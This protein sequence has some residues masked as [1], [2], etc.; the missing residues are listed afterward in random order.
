M[1][2]FIL[3][4]IPLL[5]R[6][7]ITQEQ[8]QIKVQKLKL[9]QARQE[10]LEAD[11]AKRNKLHRQRQC[12]KNLLQ[13][14][15]DIPYSGMNC[16]RKCLILS[17]KFNK[18]YFWKK[19]RAQQGQWLCCELAV[20]SKGEWQLWRFRGGRGGVGVMLCPGCPSF[21]SMAMFFSRKLSSEI[22]LLVLKM[23]FVTKRITVSVQTVFSSVFRRAKNRLPKVAQIITM[24]ISNWEVRTFRNEIKA[25]IIDCYHFYPG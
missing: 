4:R 21:P 20:R 24:C 1:N 15:T 3:F 2:S 5:T 8:K 14:I 13:V 22:L 7:M 25:P 12:S 23:Y 9:R 19:Q 17:C 16:N 10:E 6:L 18:Q 11:Q